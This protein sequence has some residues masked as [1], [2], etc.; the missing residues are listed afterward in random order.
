[1]ENNNIT[2]KMIPAFQKAEGGLFSSVEKADVGDAVVKMREQG[3]ELMSWADPYFPVPS[4][5]QHVTDAIVENLMNGMGSHYTAPVGNTELKYELAK[6]LK[7]VNGLDVEPEKNI[8]ITPG[9]DSGLFYA[10]LPFIHQ[11]DE[12][13]I[14]DPSYPNN[15]QNTEILG[16]TVVRIPLYEEKGYQFEIED[17]EKRV[18]DKT[19]MVVLTNPNNPTTT[20]IRREK[21]EQLAEFIVKNDLILVIDHAFEEPVFDGIEM[22]TA[23][24]L[25]GMWGWSRLYL[26]DDSFSDPLW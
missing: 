19:K 23:A 13:M 8:L 7:K 17:F 5:P 16:G 20:V 24:A 12:V 1:M 6:K 15:F 18:T 2:N 14:L 3:I 21:M 22:V 9:S 25:P 4:M 10:M 26:P 11:G